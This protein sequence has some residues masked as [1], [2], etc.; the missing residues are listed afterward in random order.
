MI[1]AGVDE[2]GRG[3]LA[4]PVVAAAVILDQDLDAS[5]FCD[6]KTLTA[7]KRDQSS[8]DAYHITSP[9]PDGEGAQRAMQAALDS[10]GISPTD[11]DYIY[12][13]YTSPGPRGGL[14]FRMLASA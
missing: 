12:P 6:S 11:V 3:C 4:G 8:G 1:V 14:R 9:A 7:T 13:L 5:L 10:A 2:A